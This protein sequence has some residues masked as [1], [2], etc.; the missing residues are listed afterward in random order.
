MQAW[1]VLLFSSSHLTHNE[2]FPEAS[3]ETENLG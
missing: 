3:E 1:I 2:I